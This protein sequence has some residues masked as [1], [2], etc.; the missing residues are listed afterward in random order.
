MVEESKL[1]LRYIDISLSS[2]LDSRKQF[3]YI[4]KEGLTIGS[5]VDIAIVNQKFDGSNQ[6]HQAL[7]LNRFY[8]ANNDNTG[9]L[10]RAKFFILARYL[11]VLLKALMI[12][13]TQIMKYMTENNIVNTDE[14]EFNMPI[15]E[16]VFYLNR[17]RSQYARL[18]LDRNYGYQVL[19][20]SR[21]RNNESTDF[22]FGLSLNLLDRLILG[23]QYL[24]KKITMDQLKVELKMP[25]IPIGVNPLHREFALAYPNDPCIAI[26]DF[27][28][29]DAE[30]PRGLVSPSPTT[31]TPEAES[32]SSFL[33][34]NVTTAPKKQKR[35]P[36]AS[37]LKRRQLRF[38]DSDDD[39]NKP[40]D[41][42]KKS[43]LSLPPA[44]DADPL[45]GDANDID[46]DDFQF[47]QLLP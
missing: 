36:R 1:P 41:A 2:E 34:P 47:S 26:E 43:S 30:I 25:K 9:N 5:G 17:S 33:K 38:D 20:G 21:K 35:P 19:F 24:M 4:Q 16:K 31:A 44:S 8:V 45:L 29:K 39:L 23:L 14:P 28:D 13:Q 42:K 3:P 46:M 10:R 18:E 22:T 40:V 11:E 37:V 6:W 12:I 32:S 27:K 7:V 15:P